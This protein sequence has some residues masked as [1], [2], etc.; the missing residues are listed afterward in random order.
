MTDKAEI[1]FNSDTF[2]KVDG[3]TSVCAPPS[4]QGYSLIYAD[5]QVTKYLLIKVINTG[6]F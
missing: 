5:A 4:Q 2:L 3:L 1:K 6:S